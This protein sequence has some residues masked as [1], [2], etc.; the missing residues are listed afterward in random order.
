MALTD[1]I[2]ALATRI[3]T[4]IKTVRTEIAG[5]VATSRTISTTA[6]LTGGGDLSAN[7]TLGVTTGTT[8]GTVATGDHTHSGYLPTT[9]RGPIGGVGTA[10][11]SASTITLDAAYEQLR[12]T[13][14][15]DITVN[16]SGGTPFDGQRVLIEANANSATRTVT[17]A[18]G[19]ETSVAVPERTLVVPSGGWGYV[20]LIYRNGTWR[21]IAMDP[22]TPV[23]AQSVTYAATITLDAG[24]GSRF[25]TTAT[26]NLTL[27][28]PTNGID[29]QMVLIAVTAS[30]ANRTVTFSG[31]T[32]TTGLVS[33]FTVTNAKTAYFGLRCAGGSSWALLA[34]TMDQ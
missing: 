1:Q 8:S 27:N 7:R 17:F 18:S 32:L 34:Q 6:P 21:L 12:W 14:N 23:L 20:S 11:Y 9:H 29:G 26:G 28:A 19:F 5:R 10:T 25:K 13:L 4:E 24:T 16:V 22:V 31:I 15:G 3:A 30:G 33:P 2:A